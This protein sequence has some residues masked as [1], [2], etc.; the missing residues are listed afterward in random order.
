MTSVR[1]LF[2]V[3]KKMDSYFVLFFIRLEFLQMR[4]GAGSD[5]SSWSVLG[6]IRNRPGAFHA[7]S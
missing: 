2:S 1:C 4:S 3:A 6:L 5:L 7:V